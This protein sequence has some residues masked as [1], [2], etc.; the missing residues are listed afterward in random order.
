MAYLTDLTAA[1]DSLLAEIK[2]ETARRAALVA[3][4]NPPPTTYSVG[5]RNVD[6]NGW[7]GAVMAHLKEM[8]ELIA[9]G[10]PAD[11]GNLYET[12]VRAYT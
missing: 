12:H 4:G 3:A 6:W 8:N 11:G 7:L 2:G 1:R 9:A 5:G 10:D